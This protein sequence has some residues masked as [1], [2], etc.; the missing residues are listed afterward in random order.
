MFLFLP[1]AVTPTPTPS[2]MNHDLAEPNR[3]RY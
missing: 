1:Q 2:T 3:F